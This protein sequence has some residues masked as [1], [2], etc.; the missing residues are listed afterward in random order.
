MKML[1]ACDFT[2]SGAIPSDRA[3]PLLDIPSAINW[4]IPVSRRDRGEEVIVDD[5]SVFN[6]AV[7]LSKVAIYGRRLESRGSFVT[8]A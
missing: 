4:R 5:P 2:V 3:M 7:N 6:C 8:G 1:L